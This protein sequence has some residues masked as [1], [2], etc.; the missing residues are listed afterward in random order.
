MKN[1]LF[2][3]KEKPVNSVDAVQKIKN[4]LET[5][6]KRQEHLQKLADEEYAKAR[7]LVSTDKEKAKRALK[8][9]KRHLKNFKDLDG[10]I[11]TLEHH[12]DT[13]EQS[14]TTKHVITAIKESTDVL[15]SSINDSD[16]DA[17]AEI[18]DQY[19]DIRSK[20]DE[21]QMMLER[22]GQTQGVD[23]DELLEELEAL[24]QEDLNKTLAQVNQPL[25]PLPSAPKTEIS[26]KEANPPEDDDDFIRKLQD[27]SQNR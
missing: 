16:L 13:L 25:P 14:H 21:F 22:Q 26:Q 20:M 12:L 18:T 11:L 10:Y 4:C 6:E 7:R 9:W 15:K 27:W 5:L 1:F 24:E 8:Q 19:D 17:M 3:K 23:E 2:G